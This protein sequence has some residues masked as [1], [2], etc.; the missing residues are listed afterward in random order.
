MK[1]LKLIWTREWVFPRHDQGMQVSSREGGSRRPTG[2]LELVTMVTTLH[3]GRRY[4]GWVHACLPRLRSG[5]CAWIYDC[6]GMDSP[7]RAALVV[8]SL[9]CGDAAGLGG[10]GLLVMH[11]MSFIDAALRIL[12]K[13]EISKF[14]PFWNIVSQ[15]LLTHT[16][17]LGWVG[18]NHNK[19]SSLAEFEHFRQKMATRPSQK[20]C[21]FGNFA[22][23]NSSLDRLAQGAR[24]HG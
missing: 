8:K 4:G 9:C 11:L 13:F 3:W 19:K 6:L 17:R 15:I 24:E 22:F 2:N 23:R 20:Y 1:T 7:Q 18:S 14:L 12:E 16:V 21:E 5:P 10:R